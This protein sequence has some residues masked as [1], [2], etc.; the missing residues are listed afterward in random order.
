MAN[1]T[2]GTSRGAQCAAAPTF[3][4]ECACLSLGRPAALLGVHLVAESSAAGFGA[5][6]TPPGW[7]RGAVADRLVGLVLASVQTGP[8]DSCTLG[9][10]DGGENHVKRIGRDWLATLRRAAPSYARSTAP[11]EI[12]R[13]NGLNGLDDCE[14]RLEQLQGAGA[15]ELAQ[16]HRLGSLWNLR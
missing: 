8:T 5:R 13:V 10:C 1:G 2:D 15:G 7:R 4:N 11:V 9:A 14:R 16:A 6:Q 12:E 3:R